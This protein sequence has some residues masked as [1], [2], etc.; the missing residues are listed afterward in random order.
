MQQL[1]SLGRRLSPCR[2]P[3]FLLL[4]GLSHSVAQTP[5]QAMASLETANV[6]ADG[7]FEELDANQ[8]PRHWSPMDGH[9]SSISEEGGN[10]FLRL[11][12]E[13]DGTTQA[14][15][16]EL[17]VDATWKTLEL[18]V[19]LRLMAAGGHKP[20]ARLNCIF[21]KADGQKVRVQSL[22]LL[23]TLARSKPWDGYSARIAVPRGTVSLRLQ[24]ELVNS[25]Q[26]DFDDIQVLPNTLHFAGI[27]LRDGIMQ[28]D[29]ETR[30]AHG[31]PEGW[32][33]SDTRRMKI[34]D[35]DGNH[36]LRLRN[37]QAK[38]TL[39][40]D[41]IVRL[42]PTWKRVK[43]TARLRGS[44]LRIGPERTDNARLATVF[45]DEA[46]NRVGP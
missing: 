31:T 41:A 25:G 10:H 16:C 7:T 17:P 27:P 20:I 12:N 2:A 40:V 4:V 45:L 38:D 9:T 44:A 42:D 22:E 35:E 11:K 23:P 6:F 39:E 32:D 26:A 43:L 15:F 5:V 24:P 19:R 28:Q 8:Q 18:R 13:Q 21:V 36:F 46:L 34:L 30:G 29:F 1:F 14:V 37:D 3:V 33:L